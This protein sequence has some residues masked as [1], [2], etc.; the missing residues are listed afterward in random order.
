VHHVT[1]FDGT[2]VIRNEVTNKKAIKIVVGEGFHFRGEPVE[3]LSIAGSAAALAILLDQ[4]QCWNEPLEL[5]NPVHW[6]WTKSY[7]YPFS[8][9]AITPTYVGT[10]YDM[11]HATSHDTVPFVWSPRNCI[12]GMGSGYGPVSDMMFEQKMSA[13]DAVSIARLLDCY[14][15]GT[16]T[17]WDGKTVKTN[18][19]P[20]SWLRVRL[21]YWKAQAAHQEKIRK[22]VEEGNKHHFRNNKFL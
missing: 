5:T 14:T 16:L 7:P 11:F 4:R 3:V 2:K 19:K 6:A 12:A 10:V 1:C 18:V 15:G 8:V 22:I 17:V 21:K 13:R 9:M 20:L